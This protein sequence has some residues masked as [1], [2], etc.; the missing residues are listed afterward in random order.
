MTNPYPA[1]APY[2]DNSAGAGTS[3]QPEKK[4]TRKLVT[5]NRL[6]ALGCAVAAGGLL[7]LFTGGDDAP[8]PPSVYVV[9]TTEAVAALTAV[10]GDQL[11]AVPLPEESIE[12]GTFQGEEPIALVA[13]TAETLAGKTT[14]HPLSA[15]EQIRETDFSAELVLGAA[16]GPGERYISITA[17]VDK[18][19]AGL[20]RPG[21]RVDVVASLNGITNIVAED[22]EIIAVRPGAGVYDSIASE[23]QKNLDVV[24]EDR[25]PGR[26]VP[27]QYILRVDA[28]TAVDLT[29][30]IGSADQITL[31]LYGGGSEQTETIPADFAVLLCGGDEF[32]LELLE[33]LRVVGGEQDGNEQT[34][35]TP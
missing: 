2:I 25:I 22:L 27:K 28:Q 1:A 5:G 34:A 26:P 11:E 9:R 20:I 24:V 15:A 6:I 13:A 29:A 16:A 14:L 18:A 23:Q 10:T 4:A 31:L 12:P 30:V 33:P 17:R 35:P 21:D 3:N 19:V 32:C 7:L 8:P